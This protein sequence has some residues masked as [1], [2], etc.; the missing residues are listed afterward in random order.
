MALPKSKLKELRGLTKKKSR[1]QEKKFLIEGVRLVGEAANSDFVILEAYYTSDL[2]TLPDASS[3]LQRLKKKTQHVERMSETEMKTVTDTVTA[4]GLIAVLRRKS[5]SPDVV[6]QSGGANAVVV[7]LD[8]VSDP[9]NLGS[10]VRTCDWFGVDGILLGGNSVELCNPKVLRSTMGGIFHLPI[11]EGVDLLTSI[12]KAKGMGYTVY[13]TD[14]DGET[15]F[16]RVRY[17]GKSLIVFGNE[18]W[19]VSDQ[20]NQLADV[21]VAIRRYGAVESLNVGVACGVI[22]SCVHR[23][24]DD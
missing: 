15:H 20:V 3:V 4:Q 19:G 2:L 18:A 14:P 10:M 11:A 1:D 22:L 7:A 17:A 12:S 13:V 23:L 8:G 21:R 5:S 6:L 24:T 9:G 16:D